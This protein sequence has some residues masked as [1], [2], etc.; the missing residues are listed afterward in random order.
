MTKNYSFVPYGIERDYEIEARIGRGSSS[1]VRR[2]FH[3]KT[4]AEK[5][6][7]IVKKKSVDEEYWLNKIEELKV[8]APLDHPNLI[9]YFEFSVDQYNY[10][11]IMDY[12]EA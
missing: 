4:G 7:K 6:I 9:K 8:L 5:A 11:L 2:C 12:K 3:L 1:E 10:Y